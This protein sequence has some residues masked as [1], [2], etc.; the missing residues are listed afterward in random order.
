MTK[1]IDPSLRKQIAEAVEQRDKILRENKL[2]AFR[3]YPKQL[4][5]LNSTA[6]PHTL[7]GFQ[8][9]NQIGKSTCAAVAVAMFATGRY[10]DWY[11]GRRFDGPTDGWVLGE[12]SQSVRDTMQRLLCGPVGDPE[13]L[14]TGFIPK[15]S[16]VGSPILSHGTG[17]SYDSI[18]VRHVSGGV[19]TIGFRSY[20]MS[21]EKLQSRTL[22]Y[23][24]CDEEPPA[25][26]V[27]ELLARMIATQGL[28]LMVYTP[29]HGTLRVVKMFRD[30]NPARCLTRATMDDA[31]H[32]SDP[33][34]REAL[35]ST[36]S[37]HERDARL[38]GIPLQGSSLVYECPINSLLM[39]MGITPLGDTGQYGVTTSPGQFINT[40]YWRFLWGI[41]FGIGTEH[42]FA[43]VLIGHDVERGGIVHV[44]EAFKMVGCVPEMHAARM[45]AVAGAVRVAYPHDGGHLEKGSGEALIQ[46]YKRAGLSVLP[47]NATNEGTNNYNVEPGIT[48]IDG[49]MRSGRLKIADHLTELQEEMANYHR[50]GGKIVK[51]DD[52]LVDALRYGVM[53]LRDARTSPLGPT[54]LTPRLRNNNPVALNAELSGD[55]LF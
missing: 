48:L 12:S 42:P 40:D 32:L 16:I 20:E 34:I 11:K 51:Q 15:S 19:S 49:L 55:D 28:M 50:E 8:A 18:R 46:A 4:E 1:P 41:D 43:A 47:T 31:E 44:L 45:R 38:R 7:C 53:Q 37:L 33:A 27:N 6:L 36:F 9:G 30:S 24:L 22:H 26:I 25:D 10:P 14:G 39:P 17:G 3:P 23:C 35:L 21:R 54:F 5:F 52:D 29:L 2:E 13:G